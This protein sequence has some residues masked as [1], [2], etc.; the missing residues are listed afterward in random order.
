MIEKSVIVKNVNGL[1]MKTAARVAEAASQFS[2][3]IFLLQGRM[4][5]N[6]KSIMG[7]IMLAARPSSELLLIVDGEDEAIVLK[8][9]EKTLNTVFDEANLTPN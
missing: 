2:A 1:D 8:Q 5:V 9:F 7:V 3:D 4:K 6:A